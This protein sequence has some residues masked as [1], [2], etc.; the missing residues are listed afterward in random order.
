MKAIF[1]YIYDFEVEHPRLFWVSLAGKIDFCL[2]VFCKNGCKEMYVPVQNSKSEWEWKCPTC[3]HVALVQPFRSD[4]RWYSRNR[5]E[6]EPHVQRLIALVLAG[7]AE[8]GESTSRF[9]EALKWQM[10]KPWNENDIALD[11]DS[12]TIDALEQQVKKKLDALPEEELDEFFYEKSKC[13]ENRLT[14]ENLVGKVNS[15][16]EFIRKLEG[17]VGKEKLQAVRKLVVEAL[18]AAETVYSKTK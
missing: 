3:G 2:P 15:V 16:Y 6:I 18:N 12:P 5:V 17:E 13:D 7:E 14:V 10:K 11:A 1:E 9:E 4:I 8:E